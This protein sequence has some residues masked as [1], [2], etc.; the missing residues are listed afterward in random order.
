MTVPTFIVPQEEVRVYGTSRFCGKRDE[1]PRTK[2]FEAGMACRH[3]PPAKPA[4]NTPA[5]Q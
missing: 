5:L 1:I 4:A 3:M 2:Y